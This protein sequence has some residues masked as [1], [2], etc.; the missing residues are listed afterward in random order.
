MEFGFKRNSRE[1]SGLPAPREGVRRY[2]Y[3]LWNHFWTFIGVNLMFVAFSLPVVTLPAALCAMDRVFIKLVRDGY[4]LVWL[5]FRDEFKAELPQSLPLGALFGGVLFLAYYL[6]S[7]GV[8]YP[9]SLFGLL[10]LALGI[11]LSVLGLGLGAY[12]FLMRAMFPI[13]N[14]DV[15]HNAAALMSRPAGRGWAAA[16]IPLLM[17]VLVMIGAPVTLVL[18]PLLL[19]SLTQYTL[20]FVLNDPIQELVVSPWEKS[21]EKE[22]TENV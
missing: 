6:L 21:Q 19:V 1:G 20:C 2:F 10:F 16:G 17:I 5:E 12:T 13:R 14:R 9:A 8:S 4:A 18:L 3:L 7:L 22:N 11:F 15:L